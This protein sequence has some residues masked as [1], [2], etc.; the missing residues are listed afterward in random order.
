M[1]LK[2][3]GQSKHKLQ[4]LFFISLA[5][6]FSA[7]TLP[8]NRK[9]SA[10]TT[11]FL[12]S[13][14]PVQE[15]LAN[16]PE[17]GQPAEEGEKGAESAKMEVVLGQE[18]ALLHKEEQSGRYYYD[19]LSAEEQLW[20]EDMYAI[21]EGMYTDVELSS[22]GN[23]AVGEQGMDKV[24]QCVMNDHPELFYVK[25]YTY[26]HYTYG[27]ETKKFHFSGSYT[28][29][30]TERESRQE[31]I[32]AIVAECLAGIGMEASQYDK[33]KYVYEYLILNTE[34][35][36]QAE[37]N[38]NIC[39]VF[40]GRQSVCQGYAKATQYLLEKLG[41]K[42]AMVIGTVYGGESHAWN[43]VQVDGSYYYVDTTWGDAS[44]QLSGGSGI[45]E[46]SLPTINYDYLCVTTEQLL[47]T[48][49]IDNIAAM[50]A[51]TD[52]AANYYVREG[53]Y[54]TAYDEGQVA[55]F[56][57]KG[58]EEN[59]TD[60]TLQCADKDVFLIFHEQ[61]IENQRIFEYLNSPDG[62]IAYAED[63]E[64]LSLTF[65]LVNE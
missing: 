13:E 48:H 39:S 45:S 15:A 12:S 61:L 18:T 52:M 63:G 6:F 29:E 32:D 19:L 54:F 10:D 30:R 36:Q 35:N 38:Q 23:L 57:E 37:D 25:G 3:S 9:G 8:E 24:F 65:W 55:A 56:F 14:A 17:G 1:N 27:G 26:T 2:K 40:L 11:A 20:Y 7:C 22:Q 59:R 16:P 58:Y 4:I 33:V 49:A 21:M 5:L 47:K 53:A 62:A 41:V 51:C 34:Y 43:L 31:Q 28:M 42:T 60:V 46:A 50:P 64:R 44:Y